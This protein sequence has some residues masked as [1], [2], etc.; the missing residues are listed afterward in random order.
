MTRTLNR[1]S[2][3]ASPM[4]N[5]MRVY[6]RCAPAIPP[7]RQSG[8]YR[9]AVVYLDEQGDVAYRH[10]S[11]WPRDDESKTPLFPLASIGGRSHMIVRA[12]ADLCKGS[13]L[14]IQVIGPKPCMPQQ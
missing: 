10:Q 3:N 2:R 1:S 4:G 7:Q 6:K 12:R 8:N 13:T 9:F 5:K 11:Q 14:A